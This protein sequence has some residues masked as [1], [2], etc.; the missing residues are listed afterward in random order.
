MENLVEHVRKIL[1]EIQG[2]CTPE[3]A[4]KFIELIG[5]IKPDLCLEIGVF[6][7]SS[8]IPQAL[9]L[10][11]NNKGMLYGIDPWRND[12]ALEEMIHD[13]HKKWWSNLNLE[14]VY[15]HC[16]K[17]IQKFKVENFCTLIRDKAENVVDQFADES[18]DILHI[19]GNHSEALSFKDATLYLPKV[20][21]GGYIM[22]DD[23]WWSE[24]NNY[25]TT[26]KAIVHLLQYCDKVDL[27]NTDCMLLQKRIS[28]IVA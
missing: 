12:A 11:E 27:V 7:G 21:V 14:S 10:K 22:F 19:D 6:G 2:W 1:P 5:K 17:N 15:N 18:I 25:V 26:R 28:T 23:I 9:A 13:D 16:T 8:F 4:E 20:K 24:E 3:K